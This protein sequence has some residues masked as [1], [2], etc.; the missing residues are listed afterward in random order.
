MLLLASGCGH[1]TG[2]ARDLS[3][4]HRLE[5]ASYEEP[6]NGVRAECSTVGA[7]INALIA[8]GQ[9]AEAEAL[10]AEASAGGLVSQA[11][12]T[13]KLQTIAQLSTRVGQLS[14]SLQ[15]AKDFPSQ[16]KDYTLFESCSIRTS[17]SRRRLS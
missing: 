11:W 14:A 9:F 7:R 15:R 10:I 8:K 17:A 6:E 12:A 4:R 3:E 1:V 16:L 2:S 13:E 5:H